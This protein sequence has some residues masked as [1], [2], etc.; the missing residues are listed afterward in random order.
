MG[1]SLYEPL[2]LR[3][4]MIERIK[5]RLLL[6]I[7]LASTLEACAPL[8]GIGKSLGDLFKDIVPKLR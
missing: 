3:G 2:S 4:K 8:K 6:L 1:H 7:V 5:F